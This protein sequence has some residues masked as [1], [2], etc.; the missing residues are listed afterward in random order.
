MIFKMQG[1]GGDSGKVYGGKYV[2]G[3]IGYSASDNVSI[4]DSCSAAT[5]YATATEVT[6]AGGL[7]GIAYG[8]TVI[9]DCLFN[10]PVVRGTRSA[11]NTYQSYAGGIVG[12]LNVSGTISGNSI[13]T[14]D[15]S[16]YSLSHSKEIFIVYYPFYLSFHDMSTKSL[17]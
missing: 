4:L 2:G 9:K 14:S 15:K 11:S 3:L 13:V 17:I 6:Y 1:L 12:S 10:G 8:D 7:V 5:V 16:I